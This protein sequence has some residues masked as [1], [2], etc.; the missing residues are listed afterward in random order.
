MTI[1]LK[2]ICGEYG[3]CPR[4][5]RFAIFDVA[6][7]D[8]RTIQVWCS[9]NRGTFAV[10]LPV[11]DDMLEVVQRAGGGY[12]NVGRLAV[13]GSGARETTSREA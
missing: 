9:G 4:C 8:S 11:L 6:D 13:E 7:F 1:N 2:S 12:S 5:G 3:P 10:P